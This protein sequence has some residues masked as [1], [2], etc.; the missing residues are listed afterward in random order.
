LDIVADLGALGTAQQMIDAEA[1]GEDQQA[2]QGSDT[3][4]E[5]GSPRCG[6]VLQR[7]MKTDRQPE[8]QRADGGGDQ[9]PRAER[10]RGASCHENRPDRQGRIGDQPEAG[11][12]QDRFA[13]RKPPDG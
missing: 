11:R 4:H 9:A 10:R 12:E 3:E 8:Q 5:S 1:N 2:E 7:G 13:D 6:L